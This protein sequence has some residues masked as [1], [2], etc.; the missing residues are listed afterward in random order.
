M[1]NDKRCRRETQGGHIWCMITAMICLFGTPGQT[2]ADTMVVDLTTS[3]G[4]IQPT[5]ASPSILLDEWDKDA[6]LASVIDNSGGSPNFLSGYDIVMYGGRN[7][8]FFPADISD[9]SIVTLFPSENSPVGFQTAPYG[10][11]T[12]NLTEYQGFW[13]EGAKVDTVVVNVPFGDIRAAVEAGENTVSGISVSS[14]LA[15]S[16]TLVNGHLGNPTVDVNLAWNRGTMEA[17]IAAQIGGTEANMIH[18]AFPETRK[19]ICP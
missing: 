18:L 17:R 12:A 5:I 11:G 4:R 7:Y 6:F 10:G 3:Y 15:G 13:R 2:L 19:R 8:D 16:D 1:S 9:N 14:Y